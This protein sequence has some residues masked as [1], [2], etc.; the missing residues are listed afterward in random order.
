MT[1]VD[2][3][4]TVPPCPF[5]GLR[6]FQLD[7]QRFFLGRSDEVKKLHAALTGARRFVA[8]VGTSGCGKSSLV[9]AGLLPRLLPPARPHSL[10]WRVVEVRPMG[11]PIS[12]LAEALAHLAAQERS[13]A[14]SLHPSILAT[15]FRAGLRRTTEGL[16]D[17]IAEAVPDQDAP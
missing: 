9:K 7:E 13:D 4:A 8:V 15:R 2:E 16:V 5:P 12:Q 11:A 1:A 3:A 14:F 10:R 17:A 6:P